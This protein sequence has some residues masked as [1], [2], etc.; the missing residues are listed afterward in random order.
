MRRLR[1]CLATLTFCLAPSE[2]ALGQATSA[3]P[4]PLRPSGE[5]QA[6]RASRSPEIDGRLTDEAWSAAPPVSHFTQRDPEEGKPATERTEVRFLYDDEAL[7]VGV[8]LFDR[9]PELVARRLSTRDDEADADY[10]TILLDSMHDHLTGAIFRVS[11]SNVQQDFILHNDSFWD[12]SWDAVWQS[13]VSADADGWTAEIRIPLSQ[14]R[15]VQQDRPTWGVNVER[16]IRRNNESA[17]L[18]MVPKTDSGVASR[19]IHLIGMDGLQPRQRMELLPYVAA[20]SEFVAPKQAGNPYND[21][22]REFF[23]GR[24]GPQVGSDQQPDAE[25]NRQSRLRSG[26]SGSCRSE[27]EC[28]RDVLS[29]KAAVFSGGVADIQQLRSGR[30]E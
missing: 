21:G 16:F 10:V 25:R 12:S 2:F 1:S 19:M 17:W 3:V 15:F 20:R 27:S 8:R 7:F 26:G 22:S 6:V 28:V 9:H 18:E 4:P 14:L 5:V 13:Q 24:P 29:R 30:L 11:A 23:C